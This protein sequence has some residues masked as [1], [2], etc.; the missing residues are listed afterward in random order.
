MK[1]ILHSF[2]FPSFAAEL[3]RLRA[4]CPAAPARMTHITVASQTEEQVAEALQGTS[5]LPAVKAIAALVE[6]RIV[7]QA[8]RAMD[9]PRTG[10]EPY[11]EAMRL[12]D[13]GAAA[14]LANLLA[15]LQ[16]KT[17]PKG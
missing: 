10:D 8:D 7:D 3:K 12:Y 9:Y 11:T 17:A 2:L 5:G 14:G 6:R 15:E 1:N 4:H 13:A 16:Q